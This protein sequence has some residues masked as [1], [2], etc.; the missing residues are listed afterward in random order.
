MIGESFRCREPRDRRQFALVH[1]FAK[2]IENVALR[3][4]HGAGITL[5]FERQS[6]KHM[7]IR[8]S[9]VGLKRRMVKSFLLRGELLVSHVAASRDRCLRGLDSASGLFKLP[10]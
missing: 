9:R 2:L 7:V 6:M 10:A 3:N 5:I 4:L 8:V 1:I